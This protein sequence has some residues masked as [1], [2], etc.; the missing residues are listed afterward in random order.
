MKRFL[1]RPDA[2]R[3]FAGCDDETL[4]ELMTEIGKTP[5]PRKA[6]RK[7]QSERHEP[8]HPQQRLP[9]GPFPREQPRAIAGS[10]LVPR[11]L[12]AIPDHR[13]QLCNATTRP[14]T[15]IQGRDPYSDGQSQGSA[16][17]ADFNGPDETAPLLPDSTCLNAHMKNTD[18]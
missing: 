1:Q 16:I 11:S 4:D 2:L 15:T 12:S 17:R 7:G 3:A 8:R 13:F 18:Y 5:K 14:Q 9:I 6:K 10:L